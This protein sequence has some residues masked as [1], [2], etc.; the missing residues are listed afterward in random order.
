MLTIKAR[1]A[2]CVLSLKTFCR[3]FPVEDIVTSVLGS[4]IRASSAHNF[5]HTQVS[6]VTDTPF[7]V[8]LLWLMVSL[9][10]L[11]TLQC[12]CLF[13]GHTLRRE[14]FYYAFI[15]IVK[16]IRTREI[17][18]KEI[19][20]R[21]YFLLKQEVSKWRCVEALDWFTRQLIAYKIR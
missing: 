19:Q 4:E 11:F 16:R 15:V 3:R 7:C 18:N 12:V 20:K 5:T 10:H 17:C 13:L 14:Y 6:G 9:L 8:F 1:S 2:C 21:I